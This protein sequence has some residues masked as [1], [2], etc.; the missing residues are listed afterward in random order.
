MFPKNPALKFHNPQIP[1]PLHIRDN[2]I[3]HWPVGDVRETLLLRIDSAAR[4]V[5]RSVY[6]PGRLQIFGG[7]I[8]GRLRSILLLVAAAHPFRGGW[9]KVGAN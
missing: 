7:V 8:V 3:L 4:P 1:K 5:R 2:G 9:I 6:L